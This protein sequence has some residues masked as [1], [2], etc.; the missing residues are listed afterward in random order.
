MIA[1]EAHMSNG[2]GMQ[3]K[4]QWAQQKYNSWSRVNYV[5]I[6]EILYK[7]DREHFCQNILESFVIP[8]QKYDVLIATVL[9]L[10]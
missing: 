3:S 9:L 6:H 10:L 5:Y 2:S 4:K 8:I 1:T 7:L